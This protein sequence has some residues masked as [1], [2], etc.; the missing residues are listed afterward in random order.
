[1]LKDL[2]VPARDAQT[3]SGHTSIS[4][5]AVDHHPQSSI[6]WVPDVAARRTLNL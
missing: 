3:I 5:T 2:G 4:T 6:R 1:M